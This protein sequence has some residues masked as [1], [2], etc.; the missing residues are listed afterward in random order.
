MAG[1]PWDIRM[2]IVHTTRETATH[3]GCVHAFRLA[4][5]SDTKYVGNASSPALIITAAP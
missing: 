4:A 5:S 3:I 2:I 1:I